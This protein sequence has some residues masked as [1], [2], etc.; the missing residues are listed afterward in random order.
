MPEPR[1]KSPRRR[2]ALA[3]IIASMAIFLCSCVFGPVDD[4]G[5][6]A[7]PIERAYVRELRLGAGDG[8]ELARYD[9]A[10]LRGNAGEPCLQVGV[11][12]GDAAVLGDAA[13]SDSGSLLLLR[14][15]SSSAWRDSYTGLFTFSFYER[16]RRL[17]RRSGIHPTVEGPGDFEAIAAAPGGSRFLVLTS[18]EAISYSLSGGVP[19]ELGR[20]SLSEMTGYPRGAPSVLARAGGGYAAVAYDS[21]LLS[22]VI[23]F[24][25]EGLGVVQV[26]KVGW[27]DYARCLGSAADG[28]A[29]LFGLGS[30]H[31]SEVG[32]RLSRVDRA[33]GVTVSEGRLR[34]ASDYYA[35]RIVKAGDRFW[36]YSQGA[37]QSVSEAG[38][39]EAGASEPLASDLLADGSFS[40]IGASDG[41]LLVY[42][43]TEPDRGLYAGPSPPYAAQELRV[44]RLGPDLSVVWD[45]F[46]REDLPSRILAV[47]EDAAGNLSVFICAR[48]T[49]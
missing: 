26:E 32:Y 20:R 29:I 25:D 39:S 11:A 36:L 18:A 45:R 12:R 46:L 16:E 15:S 17:I 48:P 23:S 10:A 3:L 8:A 33:Y 22:E 1:Y 28:D 47:A 14:S 6:V 40:F 19:A 37:F 41:G 44:T 49:R 7:L 30:S 31:G 2:A 35:D 13:A 34:A 38:A 24:L 27:G 42:G 21:L 9:L 4:Y 5:P 43:P